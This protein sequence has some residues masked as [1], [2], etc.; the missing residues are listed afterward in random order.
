MIV[1]EEVILK[2]NIKILI[3]DYI[4]LIKSIRKEINSSFIQNIF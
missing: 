1:S 3:C 4:V 2:I